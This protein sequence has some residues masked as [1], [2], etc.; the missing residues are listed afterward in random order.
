[1]AHKSLTI[2]EEAYDALSRMKGPKESFTD[3]I[4]RLTALRR[5]GSLLDYVKTLEPDEKLAGVLERVL[6]KRD[7]LELTARRG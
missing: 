6:E 3:I 2:S 7:K 1:M 4:L 5:R